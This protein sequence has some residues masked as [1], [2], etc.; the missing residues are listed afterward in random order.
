MISLSVPIMREMPS[1]HQRRKEG[2]FVF[3]RKLKNKSS[4]SESRCCGRA[5]GAWTSQSIQHPPR[6]PLVAM[7]TAQQLT[8]W[9]HLVQTEDSNHTEGPRVLDFLSGTRS[10]E[11]SNQDTGLQPFFLL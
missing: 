6:L 8:G 10:S 11:L 2:E 7:V 9:Y 5:P 4:W 3:K 1:A